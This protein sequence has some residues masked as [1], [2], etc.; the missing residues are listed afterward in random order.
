ML[1]MPR[2]SGSK[3]LSHMLTAHGGEIFL[4]TLHTPQAGGGVGAG[5]QQ[6]GRTPLDDPPSISE[7]PGG[8]VTDYRIPDLGETMRAN[9][10]GPWFDPR[11]LSAAE[12]R[13]ERHAA[14]Y[15]LTIS[16][17]TIF[18]MQTLVGLQRIVVQEE[19]S[20][21]DL[22]ECRKAIY[23]LLA[24]ENKGEVREFNSDHPIIPITV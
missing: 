12:A 9:R 24:M 22:A 1:E 14:C 6:L 23:V 15:P 7:G 16:G 5:Q 4:H 10:L 20:E 17:T 13:V 21:E 19:M 2:R 18:N 8:R 11:A 3:V